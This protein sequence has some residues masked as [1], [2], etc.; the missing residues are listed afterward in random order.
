MNWNW[1]EKGS[2][3][4]KSAR[5]P[6]EG[7]ADPVLDRDHAAAL[8][9]EAGPDLAAAPSPGPAAGP[10]RTPGPSPETVLNLNQEVALNR[11][12]RLIPRR[13]VT[14][15]G[16]S[17]EANLAASHVTDPSHLIAPRGRGHVTVPIPNQSLDRDLVL[18]MIRKKKTSQFLKF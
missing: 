3:S 7:T 15:P 5:G 6:V 14:K 1:T 13:M 11:P 17:L 10:G 12:T 8:G 18:K 4:L 16:P 9:P 2:E